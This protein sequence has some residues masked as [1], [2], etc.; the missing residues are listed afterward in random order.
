MLTTLHFILF[1]FVG[2]NCFSRDREEILIELA[3]QGKFEM[4]VEGIVPITDMPICKPSDY[5]YLIY[6]YMA[7]G[8]FKN[9][10]MYSEK[11]LHKSL[12][13]KDTAN[14]IRASRYKTEDLY[15]LKDFE[16]GIK[17]AQF[18]LQYYSESDS[19]GI[20]YMNL[21]LGLFHLEIGENKLAYEI[22]S[23]IDYD[24]IVADRRQGEYFTNFAII[25]AEK[26]D[27]DSSIYCTKQSLYFK[28]SGDIR[29]RVNCYSNLSSSFI[30]LNEFDKA[31]IYLDSATRLELDENNPV[32]ELVY[33]N[34]YD[35]YSKLG[36]VDSAFVYVE[37][38][39]ELNGFL[40]QENLDQE[41]QDLKNSYDREDNLKTR[42]VRSS[43]ELERSHE[44]TLIWIIIVLFIVILGG[45]LLLYL[46]YK[47][48]KKSRDYL[49]I[50]QQLLRSQ[51]TPHFLYNSLATIQGMILN[52]E[53]E[54]AAKY[55]SKF[56]RLVRLILQNSRD[57]L[58]SL[59]DELEAIQNYLELQKARFSEAFDFSI[60]VSENINGE[61][62]YIPPMLMQPFVE[63]AID[64]GFK[65]MDRK[66][67]LKI[68]IYLEKQSL[69][70]KIIDNGIGL[71]TTP[72]ASITPEKESLSTTIT[73]ERMKL[74][75]KEFKAKADVVVFDREKENEQG[76][77][78][79]LTIPYIND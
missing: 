21:L 68:N 6:A 38:M 37:K 35:A 66:G 54:A 63:N 77:I 23:K 11:W 27:L 20:A 78:V 4:I 45:S 39:K 46:R 51:I 29:G 50:N 26:G 41:I 58:V 43:E 12:E 3:A 79:L 31:L 14:I 5:S 49:L 59:D 24:A 48:L 56:S 40:F 22:Y 62:T 1:L 53:K 55:L 42:I 52:G 75:A 61:N 30:E 70:C 67:N 7:L 16:R 9:S 73:A 71:N 65:N 19:T 13:K 17:S 15:F 10:L 64:H 18:T 72:E 34:Y 44:Q 33:Q 69:I 60:E 32:Y 74:L 25:Y 57:R 28:A 2:F 8:D 36:M 76:T 47:N